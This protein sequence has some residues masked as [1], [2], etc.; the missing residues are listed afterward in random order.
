MTVGAI[1]LILVNGD[2]FESDNGYFIQLCRYLLKT[3]SLVRRRQRNSHRM[4]IC[5][6]CSI[7]TTVITCLANLLAS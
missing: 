6:P 7:F 3:E 2:D 5:L 1:I 4:E